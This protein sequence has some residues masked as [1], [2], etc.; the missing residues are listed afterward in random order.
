MP[1]YA[2]KYRRAAEVDAATTPS[3][4]I[5]QLFTASR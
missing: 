2:M 5:G 1:K 4:T 3:I